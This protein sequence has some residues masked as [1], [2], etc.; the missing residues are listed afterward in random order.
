MS[1]RYYNANVLFV[2]FVVDMVP[3]ITCPTTPT[4]PLSFI[5]QPGQTSVTFNRA[6]ATD[7]SGITPTIT[8]STTTS[9]VQFLEGGTQILASNIQQAGTIPVTATA[10]DNNNNQASCTFN[11]MIES[12]S[13]Y[14]LIIY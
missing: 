5:L 9:G 13:I 14:L 8:Y 2:S 4:S 10:T 1:Y 6:T 12:K 7:D 11:L 3:V